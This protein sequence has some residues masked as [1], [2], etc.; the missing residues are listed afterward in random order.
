LR[1]SGGEYPF[2]RRIV[3]EICEYLG[4]LLQGHRPHFGS[5]LVE[6]ANGVQKQISHGYR[7]AA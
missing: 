6:V 5:L 3:A 4:A 7:G 1:I 2:V